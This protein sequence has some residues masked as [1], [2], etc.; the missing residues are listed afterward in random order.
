[1]WDLHPDPDIVDK[2]LASSL[3]YPINSP[4]LS[5]GYAF[6]THIRVIKGAESNNVTAVFIR[7]MSSP[8]SLRFQEVR[9]HD[10]IQVHAG[11]QNW[12]V[13]EEYGFQICVLH[14]E[15]T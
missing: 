5:A 6:S 14:D 1:M 2:R 10:V 3:K 8:L 11:T 4:H 15:F 7:W 12:K 9:V 13:V